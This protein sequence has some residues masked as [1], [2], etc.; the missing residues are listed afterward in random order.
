MPRLLSQEEIDALLTQVSADE[1]EEEKQRQPRGR[2]GKKAQLYD[3]KHP[4]RLSKENIRSL[5]L[6]HDRFARTFNSERS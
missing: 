4:D 1:S 2:L 5:H 3:F 6:I